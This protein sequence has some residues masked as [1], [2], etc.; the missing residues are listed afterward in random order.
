M[1]DPSRGAARTF[2]ESDIVGIATMSELGSYK[3]RLNTT[4]CDGNRTG[5]GIA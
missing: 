4:C 1:F 2:T 3:N 5:T